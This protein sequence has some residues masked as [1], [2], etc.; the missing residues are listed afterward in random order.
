MRTTACEQLEE[1]EKKEMISG[2]WVEG[3]GRMMDGDAAHC[4]E[5]G[6]S[7]RLGRVIQKRGQMLHWTGTTISLMAPTKEDEPYRLSLHH[8]MTFQLAP[9]IVA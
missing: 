4:E 3:P 8:W 9:R 2:E 1:W 7:G 5:L 6:G